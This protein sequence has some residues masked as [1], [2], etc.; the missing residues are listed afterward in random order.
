MLDGGI[1]WLEVVSAFDQNGCPTFHRVSMISR[2][3]WMT[4]T[5]RGG[6]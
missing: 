4:R 1:E 3:G 6:W 5:G 2:D